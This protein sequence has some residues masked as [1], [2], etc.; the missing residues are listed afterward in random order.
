MAY[1][2]AI[3]PF[4]PFS[5]FDFSVSYVFAIRPF[6]RHLLNGMTASQWDQGNP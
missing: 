4:L 1:R 6:V 2:I 3:V 5:R